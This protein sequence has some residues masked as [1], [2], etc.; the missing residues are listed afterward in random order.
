MKSDT[1]DILKSKTINKK[2]CTTGFPVNEPNEECCK[3]VSSILDSGAM[4]S[5]LQGTQGTGSRVQ[6][7]GLILILAELCPHL[8]LSLKILIC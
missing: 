1:E 4:T 6:L 8:R 2:T 5:I 3:C 7:V